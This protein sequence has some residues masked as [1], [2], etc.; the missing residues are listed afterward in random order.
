MLT[1]LRQPPAGTALKL[2]LATETAEGTEGKGEPLI[3]RMNADKKGRASVLA[4]PIYL[5]VFVAFVSFCEIG[6][7]SASAFKD[8][9]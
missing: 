9:G 2:W 7:I 5:S 8:A 1:P 4:S 6:P 3:T